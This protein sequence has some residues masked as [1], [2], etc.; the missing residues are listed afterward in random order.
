MHTVQFFRERKKESEKEKG[1]GRMWHLA[2]MHHI[3]HLAPV[4][5]HIF[6]AWP[7]VDTRPRYIHV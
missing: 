7:A 2:H 1:L 3:G 6:S 4:S 5:P